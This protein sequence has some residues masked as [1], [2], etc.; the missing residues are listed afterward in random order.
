MSDTPNFASKS[1]IPEQ[2]AEERND[3]L[4]NRV[5]E[6]ENSKNEQADQM[7]QASKEVEEKA[8]EVANTTAQFKDELPVRIEGIVKQGF[9]TGEQ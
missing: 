3:D 8:K 2:S 9:E 1:L 7:K 6:L 4:T 5:M